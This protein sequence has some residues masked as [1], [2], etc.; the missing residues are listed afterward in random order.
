MFRILAAM[1]LLLPFVAGGCSFGPWQASN[2][3]QAVDINPWAF[4][5]GQPVF[6]PS[7]GPGFLNGEAMDM[8]SRH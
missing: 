4:G 6:S 7:N 8:R 1:A 5:S 3:S 2:A